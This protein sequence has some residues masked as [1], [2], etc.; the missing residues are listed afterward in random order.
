M[1]RI[2]GVRFQS[3]ISG[4]LLLLLIVAVAVRFWDVTAGKVA[5]A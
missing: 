4:V 3:R 5:G 2:R 1:M